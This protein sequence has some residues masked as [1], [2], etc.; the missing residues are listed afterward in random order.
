MKRLGQL[1][2]EMGFNKDAADGAKE[3][4]VKHLLRASEGVNVATPTEKR[5]I[6]R[7]R[8]RVVPLKRDAQLAFD[9]DATGTEDVKPK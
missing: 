6:E 4:F 1:M 8:E 9:F 7:S 5:E 3:A 2:E